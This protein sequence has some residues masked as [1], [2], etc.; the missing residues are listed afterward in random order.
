MYMKEEKTI[1][2]MFDRI[3][4]RYDLLNHLLSFGQDILW[5]KKMAEEAVNNFNSRFKV[6]GSKIVLDL[7]TGTADSA[8]AILKKR[9]KVVGVD[10]SYEMLKAGNKKIKNK[11]ENCLFYPIVA[12]GYQ[13]PFKNNSFDAVTCAFGIRNMHETKL[14][15]AEIY[16][17]LKNGGRI[18]ILE[19]S[20]PE[21]IFR[22]PYLF[23]LKKIIPAI[24]S[25]F[26]VRS[27]YEYLGSSI[28]RFYKPRDFV[29][30]L[31]DSGF[32]NPKAIPLSYGCVYI[33]VG[34]KF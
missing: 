22:K 28:E 34:E 16:R 21:N 1:K 6:Q 27:A 4:L 20:L 3:V 7:A 17:I 25:L 31:E 9:V 13:L 14:A 8:I 5:R 19:F 30:L 10:I 23:Y 15:L 32:K 24:A 12:S 2:T 33:Y 18:V 11:F 26:S 29:R